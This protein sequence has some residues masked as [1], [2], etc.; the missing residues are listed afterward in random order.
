[1]NFNICVFVR[2]IPIKVSIVPFYGGAK[3]QSLEISEYSNGTVT[4]A[5]IKTPEKHKE[6]SKED[7]LGSSEHEHIEMP[8]L[9]SKHELDFGDS[10]K[11]IQSTALKIIRLQ[12]IAKQNGKLTK[13][14]EI[15]YKENMDTLSRAAQNLAII[16]EKSNPLEIENREGLSAWFE[17]K[18]TSSKDKKKKEEEK[19][20]KEDENKKKELEEKKKKEEE[21]KR[22]KEEDKRKE[23]EN[24]KEPEEEAEEGD[25]DT[26]AIN[27]PPQDA[28][29]AEAKPIGLA[30][31]GK[32][33]I[34][35]FYLKLA[36]YNKQF[37]IIIR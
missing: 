13:T 11:N 8:P 22:K 9:P 6:E 5:I 4:T 12:E 37:L 27:L 34:D 10:I 35:L 2:R 1:M 23:E 32:N 18:S 33:N 29:V 7:T 20:K 15:I 30:V 26:I 25:D 28:S 24:K 16:Q 14:Q 36:N 19:K 17:R 21:E 3:G 31:A